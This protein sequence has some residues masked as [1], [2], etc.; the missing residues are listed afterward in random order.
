MQEA[1][2]IKGAM[3]KG[4]S[5]LAFLKEDGLQDDTNAYYT[6]N[7]KYYG[8]ESDHYDECKYQRTNH[9]RHFERVLLNACKKSAARVMSVC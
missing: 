8:C 4:T 3:K 9:R 5:E 1:G 7:C 6:T 2:I